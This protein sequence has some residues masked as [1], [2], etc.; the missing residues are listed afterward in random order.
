MNTM[1]AT[2]L[3]HVPFEGPSRVLDALSRRGYQARIVRL[4]AG[5]SV[6]RYLPAEDFLVV[7]GGPM[8]VSD[9]DAPEHPYLRREVELLQQRIAADAPTLG[10]C[11]G[12]QL[13]AHA[14]GARVYPNM[15]TSSDAAAAP[16]PVLEVGWADV[17]FLHSTRDAVLEG[18][19]DAAPMFHWHGDTFDLPS[20]SVLLAS[21]EACRAQAFRL[22]RSL[23][24]LQ[25]HCEVEQQDV[26]NLLSADAAY[27]IRACG[28]NAVQR[29]REDTERCLPR[30]RSVGDRL[31]ENIIGAVL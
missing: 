1:H 16:E 25:F 13:M 30:F 19:P 29:V 10:I 9:L 2:I 3:Q 7:M 27:A 21:T 14:A 23:F 8:G 4:F 17:A 26:E 6:P 31:L 15:R 28:V 22:N 18:L 24:G 5:E 20:G 12:A 11:L